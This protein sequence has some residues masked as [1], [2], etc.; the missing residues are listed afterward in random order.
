MALKRLV[1]KKIKMTRVTIFSANIK[2]EKSGLDTI[3]LVGEY[4]SERKL[5]KKL[6]EIYETGDVQILKLVDWETYTT[7]R[8]MDEQ[9]FYEN[10]TPEKEN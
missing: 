7:T 5:L 3:E 8:F 10:S 1:K 4:R 2:T 6:K 9:T